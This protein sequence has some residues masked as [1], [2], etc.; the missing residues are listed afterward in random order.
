MAVRVVERKA[1]RVVVLVLLEAAGEDPEVVGFGAVRGR[2]AGGLGVR[3]RR[4]GG[5]QGRGRGDG[6][7]RTGGAASRVGGSGQDSGAVCWHDV[8]L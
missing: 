4:T 8:L 6:E 1:D 3:H 5:D 7:Q 2:R